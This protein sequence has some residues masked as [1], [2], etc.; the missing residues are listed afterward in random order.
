MSRKP[1]PDP[2]E[3]RLIGSGGVITILWSLLFILLWLALGRWFFL[4]FAM[5]LPLY[6]LWLLDRLSLLSAAWWRWR[7]T[8]IQGILVYSD[9]PNWKPYIEENWLPHLEG[10]VVILNWSAR[11]KWT[12]T[13]PVRIFRHFGIGQDDVN[14]NPIVILSRGL[15]HPLTYRF[16]YAFR[17]AKHG[18]SE[19]LKCLEEQMFSE[20]E[21]RGRRRPDGD[22][23]GT[24]SRA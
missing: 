21:R 9:S 20:I 10:R 12:G 11:G 17:D 14:F 8:R 22:G 16:L 13:L 1:T 7:G 5:P 24:P 6:L 3:S 19:A 18:R 4:L 2:D 23:M 15:R